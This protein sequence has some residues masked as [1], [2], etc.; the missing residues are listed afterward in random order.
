M[1]W[2]QYRWKVLGV[3]SGLSVALG[4]ASGGCGLKEDNEIPGLAAIQTTC[5]KARLLP[6][7]AYAIEPLFAVESAVIECNTVTTATQFAALTESQRDTLLKFDN[8]FTLKLKIIET[9]DSGG[10]DDGG[11]GPEIKAIG[12][13]GIKVNVDTSGFGFDDD[14]THA[15]VKA[16]RTAGGRQYARGIATSPQLWCS[17][18]SGVLSIDYFLKCPF[19]GTSSTSVIQVSSGITAYAHEV[20]ISTVEFIEEPDKEEEE[21]LASLSAD[22]FRSP[23]QPFS[24]AAPWRMA[25]AHLGLWLHFMHG[26]RQLSYVVRG[27]FS[28]DVA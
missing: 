4:L 9:P 28:A 22:W 15:D 6:P 26:W 12:L 18:S 16:I 17:D 7:G 10:G 27:W 3:V 13:A 11:G 25:S 8:L 1:V 2:L 14:K 5:D 24:L 19:P 21:D 20:T 23:N